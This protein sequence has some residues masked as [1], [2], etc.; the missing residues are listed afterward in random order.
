MPFISN[1]G[2]VISFAEFQDV[3][4]RDQRLFDANEG[5]N[6]EN[7]VEPLLIRATERIL[8]MIRSTDWWVTKQSISPA[9]AVNANNILGRQ[10]DFTELCVNVGLADYI[11]PLIADFGTE[12]NAEYRKMGYYKQRSDDLFQEL[13]KN[14]DWYDF[15]GD[16]SI[17]TTEVKK[18]KITNKRIR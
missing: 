11:L 12:D 7:V 1:R 15:D 10:N 17:A 2:S 5:I 6:D 14:G 8:S 9:P 18:G 3:A 13:I 16:G 4:D